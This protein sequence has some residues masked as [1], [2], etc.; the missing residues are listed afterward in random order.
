MGPRA[1]DY[2]KSTYLFNGDFESDPT[3]SPFD[4]KVARTEG[5][6]V[7]RDCTT[8]STGKC[9]LRISFAGTQNLG[10]A[11]A[12]QLAFVRTGTYQFR[13]FIRTEGLT[14]D[15][16]IRFR[17]SDAEA[18]ARLDEVFGQFIGSNPWSEVNHE[19]VVPPGT[20]LLQIQAIRQP[21]LKFDNKI[22]GV[23]WID[24]VELQPITEDP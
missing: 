11:A 1:N 23:A 3:Q 8:A 20:R 2:D 10:I 15:E 18:P 14:T 24:D 21:S 4:W 19:L 9:S 16:G 22:G 12:S 17:I 5:V 6:E 13:A 7:A